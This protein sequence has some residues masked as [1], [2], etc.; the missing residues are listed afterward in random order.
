MGTFPPSKEGPI[1]G[2][3][4]P[5]KLGESLRDD[6][7]V[8]EAFP[9]ER[10]DRDAECRP[11]RRGV[12]RADMGGL[13]SNEALRGQIVVAAR[14]RRGQP[15]VAAGEGERMVAHGDDVVL[16]LPRHGPARCTRARGARR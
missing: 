14:L 1:I 13:G 15:S 6:E 7:G 3:L 10:D 4:L 8:R 9:N 11:E 5:T 16:G 12:D 2:G